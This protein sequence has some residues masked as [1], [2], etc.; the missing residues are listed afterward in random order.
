MINY[1]ILVAIIITV[2]CNNHKGLVSILPQPIFSENDSFASSA[3][4]VVQG[5]S[6][7]FLIR[8]DINDKEEV[9]SMITRF[10]NEN[11]QNEYKKYD[12]YIMFFYKESSN[13]N[14]EAIRNMKKEYRYK[15]FDYNKDDDF[16]VS[17]YF[18]KSELNPVNWVP[19]YE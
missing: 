2:A 5:K 4:N 10:V 1:K 17:F 16:V 18:R 19:Q 8:G 9:K 12:N 15:L 14:E 7:Y 3:G 11:A 6:D 13:V